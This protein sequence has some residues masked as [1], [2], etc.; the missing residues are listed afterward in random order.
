ML[1]RLSARTVERRVRAVV[2]ESFE[3]LGRAFA[4]IDTGRAIPRSHG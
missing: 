4:D 2:D 1:E 3:R